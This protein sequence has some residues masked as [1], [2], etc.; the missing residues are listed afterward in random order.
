MLTNK[1]VVVRQ[2]ITKLQVVGQIILELKEI[3]VPR[4]TGKLKQGILRLRK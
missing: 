1:S 3:N 2:L 4:F